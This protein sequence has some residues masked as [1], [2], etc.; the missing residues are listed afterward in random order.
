MGASYTESIRSLTLAAILADVVVY[1]FY[2]PAA[3]IIMR[4]APIALLPLMVAYW[5]SDLYSEIWVHPVVE[6]RQL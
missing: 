3:G 6:L 2:P 4:V 5:L 1:F